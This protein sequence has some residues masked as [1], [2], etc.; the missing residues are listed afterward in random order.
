VI[1]LVTATM[2]VVVSA[3]C[4]VSRA[5]AAPS[6]VLRAPA[7][8]SA[9]TTVTFTGTVVPRRRTTLVLQRRVGD[10]WVRTRTGHS[11]A[12]GHFR[13]AVTAVAGRARY[14]VATTTGRASRPV[15]V[16]GV[17]AKPPVPKPV[18]A[19]EPRVLTDLTPGD[20]LGG[21]EPSASNDGRW[22]AFV[23]AAQLVS[24][25]TNMVADVYL[26]D[27]TTG[28]TSLVSRRPGG[29]TVNP[30]AAGGS[31]P[32]ISPDGGWVVFTSDATGL[33]PVPSGTSTGQH[34][35]LWQRRTGKIQQVTAMNGYDAEVAADGSAVVFTSPTAY[36]STDTNNL[37][38]VI[39]WD[40]VS[41]T[42]SLVSARPDGKAGNSLSE[43]ASMSDDGRRIAFHSLASD[44]VSG[45]TGGWIDVFLWTSGQATQRISC[46]PLGEEASGHSLQPAISGDGTAIV[47]VSTAD[48]LSPELAS[49][50]EAV[51]L[52]WTSS[53]GTRV[54][55]TGLDGAVPSELSHD[56]NISTDG[57]RVS[58]LSKASNLTSIA[59]GGQDAAYVWD[60]A[61]RDVQLV[62]RVPGG[63]AA[64]NLTSDV[65]LVGDGT[66]ALLS[67]YAD[68]LV[69][70]DAVPGVQHLF[71]VTLGTPPH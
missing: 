28:T 26:R 68:N 13:I 38:D 64:D 33:A 30:S 8:V 59:T 60:A 62:S 31:A 12:A 40:R 70:A 53:T 10:H 5:D 43:R 2:L 37:S 54:V 42:A 46:G 20:T 57:R 7:Q 67:S 39:L 56:P 9:G 21:S 32:D 55:S 48:D 41:G 17:T 15:V 58:F 51:V 11:T 71:L 52:R 65:R 16:T 3:L 23:T 45:D 25:D 35:F 22:L 61:T 1:R 44:L 27:T 69:P 63:E 47:Y 19:G 50:D 14:R 49:G 29:L 18:P 36:D 34:V 24:E 6:I 4:P 66:R